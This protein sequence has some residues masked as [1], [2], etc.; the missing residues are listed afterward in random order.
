MTLTHQNES[1][2]SSGARL[3][4]PGNY[5]SVAQLVERCPEE[6]SVGGSTP[7]RPTKIMGM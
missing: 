6:A 1:L 7:P 2:G 5:G 4:S 3:A